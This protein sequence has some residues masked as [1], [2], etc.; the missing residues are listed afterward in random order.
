MKRLAPV[1]VAVSLVACASVNTKVIDPLITAISRLNNTAA[2]DLVVA[3]NVAK[4]ATPPDTD[5]LNCAVAGAQAS[6]QINAV[7]AAAGTA[8]A[9]AITTAEL[10]S[11]F[12]PGSQQYNAVKQLLVT[13]CAAKAQDVLGPA[14]V[15]AAGGVVGALATANGILPLAAAAP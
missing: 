6:A 5:G 12:Q 13:G 11:L 2:A 15:L 4:A 3:Q 9:G 10:A 7:L 8:N 14:G 1:I